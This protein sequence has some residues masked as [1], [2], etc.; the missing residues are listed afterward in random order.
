MVHVRVS[1]DDIAYLLALLGGKRQRDTAGIHGDGFVNQKT[2]QPLFGG[3]LAF[4]IE[5]AW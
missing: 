2:S 5:G 1:D 4:R 3:C